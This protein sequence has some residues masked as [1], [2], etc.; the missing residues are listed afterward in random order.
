MK[1]STIIIYCLFCFLFNVNAQT[2]QKISLQQAIDMSI[3]N[4]NSLK[5][6]AAKILNA[7]TDVQDARD[8]QLPD[9]KVSGSY[10]WLA[11]A[12]L[13]LASNPN[14]PSPKVNQV[15]YALVNAS[16]PIYAAGKIK[17]GI[18]SAKYL[19]QA[20]KLQVENDKEAI[21]FNAI[22]AYTNLYKA[23]AAV[24]V[25][26]ESLKSSQKRDTTFSRLEQN[27]LLA[28]NDLLKSQLQT[29]NVELSLLDAENNFALANINM[30]LMLGLAE[31]TTIRIDSNFI[32]SNA[33]LKPFVDYENLALQN[34]KDKQVIDIQ[35]KAAAIAVKS[36]NA[37]KYP[38]VAITGGYI[39]AD[40]PKVLSITNALNIGIGVQYNIA[41]L[42]KT[43]TKLQKAKAVEI[44]LNAAENLLNDVIKLQV[45]KDYQNYLLAKKKIDVY[46][47]AI[48]QATENA[49]IIQNKYDNNLAN[50]TELLDANVLLLQTRLTQ[51]AAKADAALVYNKLLETTG[52]LV[53]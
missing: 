3:K 40:V 18:E 38:T 51:V 44:Q 29:S 39:N 41:S 46:E 35:K 1:N 5:I 9:A 12:N 48:I 49:R 10:L 32:A 45:N 24:Y 26:K 13:K 8:R 53:K 4:S 19:E 6:T 2:V 15:L 43:N 27:G 30:C 31:E 28:K 14:A 25:L 36:A 22:E 50:I 42:W 23:G 47:N 33:V 11:G 20:A 16:M 37:D 52:T 17:Y 21:A 34:R 7:S